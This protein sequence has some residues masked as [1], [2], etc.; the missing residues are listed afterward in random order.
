MKTVDEPTN[1]FVTQRL[2]GLHDVVPAPPP[3]S[4]AAARRTAGRRHAGRLAGAATLV[5]AVVVG[6]PLG[7]TMGDPVPAGVNVATQGPTVVAPE[8]SA[9]PEPSGPASLPTAGPAVIEDI[10]SGPAALGELQGLQVEKDSADIVDEG[11]A[12]WALDPCEATAYPQDSAR[13]GW[14]SRLLF[15]G[16]GGGS[17]QV[18]TYP[19]EA[20][21]EQAMAAMTDAVTTCWAS[22]DD[23]DATG[24]LWRGDTVTPTRFSGVARSYEEAATDLPPEVGAFQGATYLAVV[25]EGRTVAVVQSLQ[26]LSG[27]MVAL[28]QG[29]LRPGSGA[30]SPEADMVEQ[31]N[32]E[33]QAGLDDVSGE[34]E[35]YLGAATDHLG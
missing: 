12:A 28:A 19:D 8:P 10:D 21:A 35:R 34:A 13:T 27:G 20:T 5:A 1:D 31:A 24:W 23:P 3:R 32:N 6:V 18:A 25:R 9:A 11:P 16:D 17:Y 26:D 4:P 14:Y 22:W 33:V 29:D 2:R 7:L 30:P 15:S